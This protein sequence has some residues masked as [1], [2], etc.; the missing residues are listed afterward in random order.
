MVWS[1]YRVAKGTLLCQTMFL[2]IKCGADKTDPTD[3][4]PGAIRK[5]DKMKKDMFLPLKY[6]TF[7]L[8]GTPNG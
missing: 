4:A 7:D 1:I 6:V 3:D 8:F 5:N 2:H